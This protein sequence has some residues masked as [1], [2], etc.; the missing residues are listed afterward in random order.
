M[1][2]RYDKA[3]N[4]EI[5]RIVKNFNSK[6][7]R[8]QGIERVLAPNTILVSDLKKTYDKR[9]DL[10]RKLREL[11]LFSEKG[12]EEEVQ[13]GEW[14]TNKYQLTISKRQAAVAKANLTREINKAKASKKIFNTPYIRNLEK[15]REILSRPIESLSEKMLATRQ[16]IIRGEY[17]ARKKQEMLYNNLFQ[18]IYKTAYTA[19]A[20]PK[21]IENLLHELRQMSPAQLADALQTMPAMSSFILKYNIMDKT[22]TSGPAQVAEA[23][24]NM[25]NA[26]AGVNRFYQ[27]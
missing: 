24:E 5:A 3:Y 18:M 20:D 27:N 7:M 12:M 4:R 19:G 21:V 23:M 9:R 10:N 22:G 2:I 11:Q 14:N 25:L 13:V 17:D 8:L 6:V 1:A 15:R 16:R 26:I